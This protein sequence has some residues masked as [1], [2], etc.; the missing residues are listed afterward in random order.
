MYANVTGDPYVKTL[1]FENFKPSNSKF[2]NGEVIH[3]EWMDNFVSLYNAHL[4]Y[5]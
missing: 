3:F 4:E 1:G 2:Q 5:L